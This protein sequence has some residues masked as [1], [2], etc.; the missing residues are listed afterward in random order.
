LGPSRAWLVLAVDPPTSTSPPHSLRSNHPLASARSCRH[1]PEIVTA[2]SKDL[3]G[4]VFLRQVGK[5][6]AEDEVRRF[7]ILL[8]RG[9]GLP[10]S[11]GVLGPLGHRLRVTLA[12]DDQTANEH[13]RHHRQEHQLEQGVAEDRFAL[14]E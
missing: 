9:Y 1:S 13:G 4:D 11:G 14:L 6:G 10:A 3:D 12:K 5:I 7:A 8:G 2:S